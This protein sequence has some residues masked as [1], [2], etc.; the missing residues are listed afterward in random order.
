MFTVLWE[1]LSS[2]G[3]SWLN[4]VIEMEITSL[5]NIL[6]SMEKSCQLESPLALGPLELAL[7]RIFFGLPLPLFHHQ[8]V[9]QL[10]LG[11]RQHL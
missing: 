2:L 7:F 6:P 5:V 4:L 1:R 8:A 3:V 11:G 9:F 10:V